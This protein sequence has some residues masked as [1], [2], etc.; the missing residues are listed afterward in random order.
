VLLLND[1]VKKTMAA[2]E[3]VKLFQK[4]GLDIVAGTPEEFAAHL[5]KESAKWGRVIKE[6]G[7]RAE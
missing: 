3:Q 5:K 1:R 4:N 2:P 6:R 7:M